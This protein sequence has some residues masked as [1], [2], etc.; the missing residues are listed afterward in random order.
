MN[1]SHYLKYVRTQLI[2]LLI[3][4]AFSCVFVG[5]GFIIADLTGTSSE[6]TSVLE[7]GVFLLAMGLIGL[8]LGESL[9]IT[10]EIFK[11][12]LVLKHGIL[13]SRK[14]R[15]AI[16]ENFENIKWNPL[17][18]SIQIQIGKEK[19]KIPS[20]IARVEGNL[21]DCSDD[22]EIPGGGPTRE[23]FNL[24]REI[25]ERITQSKNL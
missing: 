24:Y 5:M 16:F 23:T 20:T 17:N 13:I 7:A 1:N 4:G 19:I 2:V 3:L 21:P 11:D 25:Q 6:A 22:P 8:W 10:L 15:T 18:G 12:R 14:S 9:N